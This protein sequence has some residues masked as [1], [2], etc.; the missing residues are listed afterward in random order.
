VRLAGSPVLELDLTDSADRGQLAPTLVD[1]APDGSATPISRG[2]LNLQYRAG[3]DKAV[4]VPAAKPVRARVRLAPQDQTVAAGHRI[5]LIV[6]S[7]NTGWAV[8]EQPGYD[9]TVRHGSSR[10]V[11]PVV[12]AAPGPG[13]LPGVAAPVPSAR[14]AGARARLTVSARRR[15]ARR[16]LVSG[17]APTGAHVRVRVTRRGHRAQTRTVLARAGRFRATFR[18]RGRGRMRVRATALVDGRT[19]RATRTLR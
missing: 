16:L 2:F 5:G 8:P 18:L 12:G 1:V 17:R 9:I 6:E 7:S 13:A 15:G 4:P 3:L 10:L 19:L 14:R 11:V